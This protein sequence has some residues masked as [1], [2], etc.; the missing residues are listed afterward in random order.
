MGAPDL[1]TGVS[2]ALAKTAFFQKGFLQGAYL[3]IEE[4]IGLVD[5]AEQDIGDYFGW[6]RL[7]IGPIGRIGHILG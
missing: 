2:H 3:F 5:E 4:V 1:Q 7:E 6:A